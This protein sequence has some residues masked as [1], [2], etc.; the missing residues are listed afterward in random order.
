[1]STIL[2]KG[3]VALSWLFQPITKWHIYLILKCQVHPGWNLNRSNDH[4]YL[5]MRVD[6]INAFNLI[7]FSHLYTCIWIQLYSFLMKM[8]KSRR[9]GYDY[10][11]WL[12]VS[13]DLWPWQYFWKLRKMTSALVFI[14]SVWQ[15]CFFFNIAH[16]SSVMNRSWST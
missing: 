10:D 12:L 1:M 4:K 13:D 9:N 8:W 5:V 11:L 15:Q 7:F 2:S 14:S 6:F 16:W 3:S